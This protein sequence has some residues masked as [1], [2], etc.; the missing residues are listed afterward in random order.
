M[1]TKVSG[2]TRTSDGASTVELGR[3]PREAGRRLVGVVV[4]EV[5]RWSW[6]I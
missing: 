2:L 5:D 1:F 4:L 3:F 6:R